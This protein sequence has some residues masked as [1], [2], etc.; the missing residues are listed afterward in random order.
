M[1]VFLFAAVVDLLISSRRQ[2]KLANLVD[3]VVRCRLF[4]FLGHQISPDLQDYLRDDVR[5]ISMKKLL[6]TGQQAPLNWE[7]EL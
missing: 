1:M 5:D 2:L 4:Q 3:L 6:D 7:L